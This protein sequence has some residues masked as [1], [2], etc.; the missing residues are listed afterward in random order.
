MYS[1]SRLPQCVRLTRYGR[2][3]AAAH[4][5]LNWLRVGPAATTRAGQRRAF[6]EGDR[7]FFPNLV[8]LDDRLVRPLGRDFAPQ[9]IGIVRGTDDRFQSIENRGIS[10]ISRL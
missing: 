2:R 9:H 6:G 4:V 7:L 1:M 10:A 5:P 8:H 3:A